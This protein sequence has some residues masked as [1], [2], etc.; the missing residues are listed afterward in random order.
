MKKAYLSPE[1]VLASFNTLC[2]LSA[3]TEVESP[4][5]LEGG[6]WGVKDVL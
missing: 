4:D 5:Y 3:S 6:D 2:V 1:C